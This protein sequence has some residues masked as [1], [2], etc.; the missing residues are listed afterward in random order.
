MVSDHVSELLT[1]ERLNYRTKKKMKQSFENINLKVD[2]FRKQRGNSNVCD[3]LCSRESR[4]RWFLGAHTWEIL[5]CIFS[6]S[7]SFQAIVWCIIKCVCVVRNLQCRK[8][9]I[10]S[11][12]ITL[13]ISYENWFETHILLSLL[14]NLKHLL[15]NILNISSIHDI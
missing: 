12:Y 14:W 2:I 11:C 7:F 6:S 13:N 3:D 9:V 5:S 10:Y 15:L 4:I 8:C 1:A